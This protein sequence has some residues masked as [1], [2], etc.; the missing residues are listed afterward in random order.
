MPPMVTEADRSCARLVIAS[1]RK[2][3]SPEISVVLDEEAVGVVLDDETFVEG[4][5]REI[6]NSRELAKV[7]RIG[8]AAICWI[9]AL[10]GCAMLVMLGAAVAVTVAAR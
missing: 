10:T 1:I 3:I 2:S 4:V 6:A 8:E 7:E 5:A 9:M